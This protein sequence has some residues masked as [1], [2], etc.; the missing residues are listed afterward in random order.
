MQLVTTIDNANTTEL[1]V[2]LAKKGD[3]DAFVRLI[4]NN[5][6]SMYRIALSILRNKHDIE[7]S[8][9]NTIVK[10]FQNI[11]YLKKDEYF[12]TWLIRILINECKNTV[13]KNKKIVNLDFIDNT[14]SISLDSSKL[15]L[16]SAINSLEDDLRIVTTLF[17]FE[18]IPQ[19]DIAKLLNIPDG[20]VRSR[21]SRA[22]SKLYEVLKDL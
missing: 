10:S 18:D 9:Q 5:K 19:K 1:D 21:L 4:D 8:I 2:R 7:D 17:Y 14:E 20:T 15:E 16:T 13:T 6:T 3:K 11:T 22:R 12:K